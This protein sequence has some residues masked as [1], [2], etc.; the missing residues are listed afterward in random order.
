MADLDLCPP[1]VNLCFARGDTFPWTFTVKTAAGTVVDITGFGFLL[2]V[3]PSDEPADNTNN[4]FQ[5]IGTVPVGTDGV[6]Q[7]EMS[8]IEADQTPAEYFFD[9]QMTDGT[10]KIRTIAKG[11]FE[12]HQDVT[13]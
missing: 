9:L 7:F 13:K 8:S 5:L 3:D 12:F 6:V 10:G 2:T 4:L 11:I 1:E